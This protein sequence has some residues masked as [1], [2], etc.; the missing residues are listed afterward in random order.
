MSVI[1][2][3]ITTI[4]VVK[5]GKGKLK[6][7]AIAYLY[8]LLSRLLNLTPILI[9]QLD[10]SL[11]LLPVI[12]FIF[13][14]LPAGLGIASL[15]IYLKIKKA[16]YKYFFVYTLLFYLFGKNGILD[17]TILGYMLLTLYNQ[18]KQKSEN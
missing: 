14:W 15:V 18:S 16:I 9:A 10:G 11:L 3:Y 1:I 2:V 12:S 5:K 17:L 13:F 4:F 6:V 8:H 7:Q